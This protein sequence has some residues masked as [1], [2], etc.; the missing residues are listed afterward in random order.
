M[1]VSSMGEQFFGLIDS[2]G[3]KKDAKFLVS[4]LEKFIEQMSS[5]NVVQVIANNAP[6]NPT[7]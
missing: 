3:I 5:M 6:L 4:I 1:L 2:R 7:T